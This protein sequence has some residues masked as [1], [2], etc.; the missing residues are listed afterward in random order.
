M[1]VNNKFLVGTGLLSVKGVRTLSTMQKHDLWI[2][3][4]SSIYPIKVNV[5]SHENSVKFL[6]I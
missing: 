4:K 6:V 2:P 5:E 3:S 1:F